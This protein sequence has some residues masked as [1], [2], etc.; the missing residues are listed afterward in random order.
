M[1]D[2]LEI[3]GVWVG[4]TL[5]TCATIVALTIIIGDWLHIRRIRR[6]AKRHIK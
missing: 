1:N 6:T 5:I 4:L 3:L 2:C